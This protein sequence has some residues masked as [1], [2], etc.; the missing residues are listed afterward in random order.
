[1]AIFDNDTAMPKE[2]IHIVAV[3]DADK[4]PV[5]IMNEIGTILTIMNNEEA[6]RSVDAREVR[7]IPKADQDKI[8]E[9]NQRYIDIT[10]QT[11]AMNYE[12]LGIVRQNLRKVAPGSLLR[13]WVTTDDAEDEVSIFREKF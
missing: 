8:L 12:A 2:P 13:M 4:A 11:T 5:K 1:M 6:I 10:M 7:N 9:V 3:F